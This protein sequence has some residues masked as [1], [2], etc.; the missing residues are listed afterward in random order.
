MGQEKRQYQRTYFSIKDGLKIM[1]IPEN[2]EQSFTAHIMDISEGGLCL[3]LKKEN[4]DFKIQK[5]D[6]FLINEISGTDQ[7]NEI[8]NMQ[9]Q[10]RWMLELEQ[11]MFIFFG[12]EFLVT[13]ILLQDDIRDFI[14]NR[15]K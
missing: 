1:C 2:Q 5:N 13:Q 14:N 6:F 7:L 10:V 8:C 9:C 12:I 15:R 4:L 11:S 3:S